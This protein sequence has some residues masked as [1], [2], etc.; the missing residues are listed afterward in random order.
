MTLN[1]VATERA[2]HKV[3]S[4]EISLTNKKIGQCKSLWTNK[5]THGQM[6]Q[7][8]NGWAK[9]Y[10]PPIYRC[11]GIKRNKHKKRYTVMHLRY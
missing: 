4:G 11:G 2:C 3:Y 9:N 1:L 5:Q 10:M 8:T 6:N 7:C